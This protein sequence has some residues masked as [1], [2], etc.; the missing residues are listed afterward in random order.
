MDQ[1][2]TLEHVVPRSYMKHSHRFKDLVK[3]GHNIILYP[4]NLN[5]HR[6]NFKLVNTLDMK[7][8]KTVALDL[9]GNRIECED[10]RQQEE[11][12]GRLSWKN[13]KLRQFIPAWPYR[14]EIA[15][16][17]QYMD[18]QYP[19]LSEM[20]SVFPRT[21]DPMV[22]HLWIHSFPPT[23]WEQQKFEI[24]QQLQLMKSSRK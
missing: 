16:A 23:E 10:R 17:C 6:S 9:Y 22:A 8:P 12:Y 21:I 14:G 4:T 7:H 20:G 1:R 3:D 18:N 5:S 24:I 19:E 13:T 11:W 2:W 15:R